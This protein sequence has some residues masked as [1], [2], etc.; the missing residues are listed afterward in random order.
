MFNTARLLRE[1]GD[2]IRAKDYDLADQLTIKAHND[3]MFDDRPLTQ[4]EY[5]YANNILVDLI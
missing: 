5:D 1:I 2:A 4:E 3:L